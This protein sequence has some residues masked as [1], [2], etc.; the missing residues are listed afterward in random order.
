MG[1]L[2]KV[3]VCECNKAMEHIP[4]HHMPLYITLW[5]RH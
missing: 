5:Q 3:D 1:R 2:Q 4:S